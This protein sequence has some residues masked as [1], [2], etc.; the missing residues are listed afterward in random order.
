MQFLFTNIF[1]RIYDTINTK[2]IWKWL[3]VNIETSRKG[4]KIYYYEIEEAGDNVIIIEDYPDDKYTSS[5]LLLG[6]TKRGRPLHLQVSR[7]EADEI[8]IITLYEPDEKEFLDF[9]DWRKNVLMS[10]L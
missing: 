8:K 4:R 9:K 5:S 2:F 10:R 7:I 6:F 1:W 3:P